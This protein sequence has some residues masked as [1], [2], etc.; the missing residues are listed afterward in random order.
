MNGD[1]PGGNMPDREVMQQA[2]EII[3]G[4]NGNITNQ[5]KDKLKELG[6]TEDQIT[7][8]CNMPTSYSPGENLEFHPQND[9]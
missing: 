3:Q 2:M 8:I 4:A 5:V 1:M 9:K 6:L 7:K